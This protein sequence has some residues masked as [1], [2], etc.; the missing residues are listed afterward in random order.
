M[1]CSSPKAPGTVHHFT[2]LGRPRGSIE[3]SVLVWIND[4]GQNSHGFS[5]IADGKA[6][7]AT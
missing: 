2:C 5:G 1:D 6:R 3:G 7:T 4:H